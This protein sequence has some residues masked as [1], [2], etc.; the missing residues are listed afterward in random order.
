MCFLQFL[1]FNFVVQALYLSKPI[2]TDRV[3]NTIPLSLND[4]GPC[5][6]QIE[7]IVKL[8]GQPWNLGILGFPRFQI[9]DESVTFHFENKPLE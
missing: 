3:C 9:S 4:W 8:Q 2:A 1:G 6:F 7:L 5:T